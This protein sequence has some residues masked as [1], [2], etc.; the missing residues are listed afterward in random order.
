MLMTFF[1]VMLGSKS[2]ISAITPDSY[3]PNIYEIDYSKL[4]ENNYSTLLFD[5]DN[6]IAKVDDLNVPQKTIELFDRL[7]KLNFKILLISNNHQERV[8]PISKKL[9]VPA[10]SEAKKPEKKPY[11]Q[12]LKQLNSK[13]ENA[14]AIGDQLLSDIIGAKKNGIKA[15]L[16]AQL[17]NE[18][19]IKTGMA[20]KLQ[21]HIIKK[22]TKENKFRYKKY[23]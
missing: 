12:A 20:Q 9:D 2:E 19:N 15:I 4:K 8:I 10:L 16:V 5:I 1:K 7:K 14:V 23:Y 6:T 18:N 21:K 17:S 13:K 3:Y 22:L 11:E